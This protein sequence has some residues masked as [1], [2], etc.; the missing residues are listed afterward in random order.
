MF[1]EFEGM[2]KQA[3][4]VSATPGNYELKHSEDRLIEQIIRP[5]GLLDPIVEVRSAKT[6]VDD[7]LEQ[8]R[9]TVDKGERV[10]V[11]VLTKRMA[12][13]LT[14]YYQELGVRCRYL[15][16]DIDT[17][18]RM[19]ILRDLRAGEFDV[20]VGI[21]LLREG[22]DLPEVSLVC[23]LDADKEGFLRNQR[24]LIQTIGRAAR[25]VN[26]KAILYADRTTDS[27]QY[28]LDETDRRREIQTAYNE[29]HGIT[30]TTIYRAIDSPLA[31]LVSGDYV[32]PRRED[33]KPTDKGA[34]IEEM[35]PRNIA[36]K[37]V[38][39]RK[40]MRKAA[41][42]LDF[43]RAAELRDRIRS[44]EELALELR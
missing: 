33:R 8:I 11:T 26:G 31:E 9:Q 36:K 14:D 16:S 42:K 25:N 13:E 5:T 1:E 34:N 6:Q 22:L 19:E 37:V 41:Q 3:V 2:V 32:E 44:L 4:Y 30:P 21:N 27:M 10:L 18:E 7:V 20:L 17:I 23:I 39:L 38:G 35:D 40:D 15:H 43:E 12:Q 29:E 28:A 24:S